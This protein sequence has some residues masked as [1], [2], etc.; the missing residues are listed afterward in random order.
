MFNFRDDKNIEN[1]N[2]VVFCKWI[3]HVK[4][5]LQFV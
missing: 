3:P 5:K 2:L 4:Y 1:K